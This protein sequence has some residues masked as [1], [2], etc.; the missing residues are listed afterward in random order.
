MLSPLY[1]RGPV[2]VSRWLHTLPGDGSVPEMPGWRWLH[3]PGHAPGHL[4]LWREGD[5]TIIAGDGFHNDT[6][7][8]RLC[9]DGAGAADAWPPMYYTTDWE[10]ARSS[11]DP[12]HLASAREG[13][14]RHGPAMRGADV[15]CTASARQ[16]L[17]S[18]RGA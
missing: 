6:A 12:A 13:D 8:V 5:R 18:S 15:R 7:G 10:N 17:R 14:H 16:Q 2:D 3:T 9:R 4:A 1:P 11:V